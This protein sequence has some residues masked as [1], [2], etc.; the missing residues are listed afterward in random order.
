MNRQRGAALMIILMIAGVLAAFFA[1]RALNGTNI[2]RDK[3]TTAAL[4]QAK[5]ALIGYAATYRELHADIGNNQEK[6]LGYLPCPDTNNDGIAEPNCGAMNV[7]VIGRLPWRT[8]GLPPLRDS[9]GE[10]LWYAVSGRAK[11]NPST[12]A[13]MNWDTLGQLAVTEAITNTIL[14]APLTNQAAWAVVFA[15]RAAIGGQTR[16][17]GAGTECRGPAGVAAGAQYLDGANPFYAGVAPAAGATSTVTFSVSE[18]V[19]LGTNNDQGIWITS[20]EIFDRVKKRNPASPN[21]FASDIRS[22]LAG[23]TNELNGLAI[24]A[25]PTGMAT[26]D[27]GSVCPV[28]DNVGDQRDAYLR[29]AW[30]NNLQYAAPTPATGLTVN[31]LPCNAVLFFAG[32]RAPGQVR[33]TAADFANPA[34]YLEGGNLAL[35]PG[36]GGYT[37]AD[38]FNPAAP[39]ADVVRCITGLTGTATQVSFA[40]NLGSFVSVGAAGS[41]TVNAI[42][43]TVTLADAAGAAGGCFWSPTQ[44]P[45]AGRNL[46]A[47]Y[48][49]KFTVP[50]SF[51]VT[52]LGSDRG[53]GFSLQMVTGSFASAPNTCGAEVDMGVLGSADVWGHDSFIFE[54]DVRQDV[55]HSDPTENHSAILLDGF[56]DHAPT[57][58]SAT[59]SSACDGSATGCRHTPANRFEETPL[60]THNQRIEIHTGCNVACTVCN[61]ATH[62]GPTTYAQINAWVGCQDCNDI[63]GDLLGAELIAATPNR[64]FSAAGSWAG[65]NWS[66][67]AGAYSHLAGANAAVLA[68]AAL[69]VPPAAGV[70]YQLAFTAAT[71]TAGTLTVS[72]GGVSA[73]L[74]VVAGGTSNSYSIRLTAT[75]AAP[76]S[77]LPNGTWVGA[78]DNFSVRPVATPNMSRCVAVTP[79]M[80]SVFFGFTSGFRSGASQQGVVLKNLFLRSE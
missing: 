46:R 67:A 77:V 13:A 45:L 65:T 54:T 22:F 62:G 75:S 32:E 49:Y 35:F 14:A 68:N 80:N 29:C 18:S 47:Y 17:G 57:A 7:S 27:A 19:R 64:D 16:G 15:P 9:A 28:V 33:A 44:F 42:D 53:N 3:V 1:V 40:A 66:V 43:K 41:V 5:D 25:L 38:Q 52:G 71:A 79:V 4:A 26:V 73:P 59:I 12:N 63:L 21:G 36:V 34:N 76:L 58:P 23:A 74:I 69:T 30:R 39:S 78:I 50:D 6:P 37:G 8:L 72:F 61:S 51:A 48:D 20:S 11:N 31:G 24:G 2:E 56:L 60:Q 70:T 55:G 10:C